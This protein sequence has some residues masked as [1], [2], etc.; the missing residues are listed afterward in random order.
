MSTSAFLEDWQP[1]TVLCPKCGGTHTAFNTMY[2]LTSYPEQYQYICSDCGHRWTDYKA[3]S[4]G[5]IQSWPSFEYE[6]VTPLGQMGW[7]CPK[8]GRVFAPHVDYCLNCTQWKPP[9]VTCID[10]AG[11]KL[12]GTTLGT[13]S[14]TAVSGVTTIQSN[15]L[16]YE[17]FEQQ[18]G[19]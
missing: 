13:I 10:L 19:K 7:I 9:K 8:C 16:K 17:S 15:S 3:Q 14:N 6:E 1:A 5:P 12:T 11:E 2:V 4:T 18:H